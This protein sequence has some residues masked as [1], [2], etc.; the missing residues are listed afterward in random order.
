MVTI[1]FSIN[2]KPIL[3]WPG[4]K[5]DELNIINA[6]LPNHINNYFEPFLGG[7]AVYLSMPANVYAYVND[8]SFDLMNLYQSVASQDRLFLTTLNHIIDYWHS[9]EEVVEENSDLL[10]TNYQRV[11]DDFVA[12]FVVD[13]HIELFEALSHHLKFDMTFYI[14]VLEKSLRQKIQ[15]MHKLEIQKGTLSD[16]DIQDNLEGA[17]KAGFYYYLRH[18]YNNSDKFSIATAI[19]S[20]IF[21]F[22]RENAY[23]S[24]FRF[25][26]K[27]EFNIPYGGISYNRKNIKAK[28][29]RLKN[30]FLISRLSNS[31]LCNLD[32]YEF[33]S[34][35]SPDTGDF[36]FLDPPYDS[37]FSSYD[38]NTFGE[39]DQHRLANY[40]L[41]ECKANFM[42][43]IKHTPFIFSLYNDRGLNIH[44]F[45]KKYM[46][47]VKERNNRDVTHLLI[48]NY[49]VE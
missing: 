29:E 9:L 18:L 1:D 40:L 15:R 35:Y 19:R 41:N 16:T 36:M 2:L 21:F 42:L 7:G 5:Q 4:G 13:N 24:M 37:D 38:Q 12:N 49:V 28:L 3:K 11:N 20:A 32:F 22:I 33:L 25:N 8:K 23:G 14:S 34:V 6:Y 17:T 27:G 10:L 43:V 48:T 45:D 46:Y 47:N 31:T 30:P 39:T 44:P 26:S